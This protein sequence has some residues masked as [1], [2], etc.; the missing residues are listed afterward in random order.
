MVAGLQAIGVEPLLVQCALRTP[1]ETPSG[2]RRRKR[3]ISKDTTPLLP[4]H[5]SALSSCQV[6]HVRHIL[7]QYL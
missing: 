4:H 1:S 7:P 3:V 6:E 5:H 2:C